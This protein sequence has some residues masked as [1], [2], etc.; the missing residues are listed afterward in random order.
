VPAWFVDLI[1]LHTEPGIAQVQDGW[2]QYGTLTVN[3][4]NRF[5][6]EACGKATAGCL[7][8]FWPARCCAV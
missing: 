6:Y 1:P 2:R 7:P 5:A 4:H 8:G 3:S